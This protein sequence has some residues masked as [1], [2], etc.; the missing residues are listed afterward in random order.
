MFALSPTVRVV[1]R[2]LGSDAEIFFKAVLSRHVL[3]E[4]G[5]RLL[6]LAGSM[7][8]HT[9]TFSCGMAQ[10]QMPGGHLP[11]GSQQVSFGQDEPGGGR[12]RCSNNL[13]QNPRVREQERRPS[14]MYPRKHATQTAGT[15]PPLRCENGDS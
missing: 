10:R 15:A 14:F 12:R 1:D 3:V 7:P 5:S 11:T 9:D 4:Q 6:I 2:N 13:Y 8:P